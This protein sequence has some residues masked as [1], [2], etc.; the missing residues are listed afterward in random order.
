MT[1][2]FLGLGE[3]GSRYAADL[4]KNG[5]DVKG[6]DPKLGHSE[7]ANFENRV[8]EAGVTI[9]AD[10]KELVE[11][12]DII[13]CPTTCAAAI[14]IAKTCAEYLKP[15]QIY[16]DFN[17]ALPSVKAECEKYISASGAD[18]VDAVVLNHPAIYGLHNPG[19]MAGP[20]AKY[21]IEVLEK[22]GM[23]QNRYMGEKNG[24]ACGFKC[25]RS[26]FMKGVEALFIEFVCAARKNGIMD[27]CIDS[28]VEN[29]GDDLRKQLCMLVKGDIIH[30]K[31]RSEEIGGIMPMLDELGLDKTMTVATTKKLQWAASLGLK[32]YFN[33][34]MPDEHDAVDAFIRVQE[35]GSPEVKE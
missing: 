25:T 11:G 30:A 14:P 31:R 5:A 12:S 10:T 18:F 13:L 35:T 2:G 8:R 9:C 29:L 27:E 7:F 23:D 15:G 24:M 20:K 22:Y 33:N 26:I 21:V 3:V 4:I 32:E 34:E 16:V 17:S 19:L 6:Y 28:V 1:I